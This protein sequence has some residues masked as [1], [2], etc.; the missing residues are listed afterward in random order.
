[1]STAT[2]Q[3]RDMTD[4]QRLAWGA[5]ER[6]SRI[7][8]LT[9]VQSANVLKSAQDAA[10]ARRRIIGATIGQASDMVIRATREIRRSA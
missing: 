7:A 8:D 1:M 4:E 6:E 9:G 2:Q 5:S 10:K 3:Y